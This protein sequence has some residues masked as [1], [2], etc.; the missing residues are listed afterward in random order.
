M[1][2]AFQVHIEITVTYKTD[3]I[4]QLFEFNPVYIQLQE[5]RNKQML[6]NF[7][8]LRVARLEINYN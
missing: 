6:I 4:K 7:F 2:Y 5:I 1:R 3:P 8:K